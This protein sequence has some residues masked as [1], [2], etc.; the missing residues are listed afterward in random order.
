ME[1]YED[2]KT[3]TTT[4]FNDRNKK[5]NATEHKLIINDKQREEFLENNQ[6]DNWLYNSWNIETFT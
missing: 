2:N 6:I 4:N 3:K 1:R 5:V